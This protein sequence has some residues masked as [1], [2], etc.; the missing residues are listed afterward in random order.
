MNVS[1]T[2]FILKTANIL[3][4]MFM[5]LKGIFNVLKENTSK[6]NTKC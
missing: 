5:T 2:V 1:V 3:E 4:K 6:S